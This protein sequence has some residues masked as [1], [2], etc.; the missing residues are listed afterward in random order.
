MPG[1][2]PRTLVSLVWSAAPLRN[3]NGKQGENH[4]RS[5]FK[6][7][8][9]GTILFWCVNKHDPM[10]T[11]LTLTLCEDE[12]TP[13]CCPE[14]PHSTDQGSNNR[15]RTPNQSRQNRHL[16]SEFQAC[17]RATKS[18]KM[19]FW[20]YF[21]TKNICLFPWEIM[22]EW[23]LRGELKAHHDLSMPVRKRTGRI[24]IDWVLTV[25][26]SASKCIL[27]LWKKDKHS[28]SF[29]LV[30]TRYCLYWQLTEK[31]IITVFMI[32][33]PFCLLGAPGLWSMTREFIICHHL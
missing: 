26:Q 4:F 18:F 7:R 27:N 33:D 6:T 12:H 23:R 2:Y 25:S 1:F 3:L 15:S 9:A 31:T 19:E 20:Y 17:D 28:F 10:D 13:R 21:T 5:R 11:M 22:T 29:L 8:C 24:S 14:T 30:M 16:V 32:Q